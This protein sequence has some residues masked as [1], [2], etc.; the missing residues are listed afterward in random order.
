[1]T[2]DCRD[3]LTALFRDNVSASSI[4]NRFSALSHSQLQTV[5]L[6]LIGITIFRSVRPGLGA[7]VQNKE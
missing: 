4:I 5:F 6:A 7:M 2:K 1:M 3:A